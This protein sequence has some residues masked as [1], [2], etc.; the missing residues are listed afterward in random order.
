M[1]KMNQS[2]NLIEDQGNVAIYFVVFWHFCAAFFLFS[3]LF[4]NVLP[5]CK[6]NIE[7]KIIKV[8][9]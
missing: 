4:C 2:K 5:P 7:P 9:F 8:W 3:V 6:G 1:K